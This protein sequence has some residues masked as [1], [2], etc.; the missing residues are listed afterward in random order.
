MKHVVVVLSLP[1]DYLGAALCVR[2]TL[3]DVPHHGGVAFLHRP[4]EGGLSILGGDG[5]P[6]NVK[7]NDGTVQQGLIEKIWLPIGLSC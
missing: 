3:Q 4:V 7:N 1:G 5:R 6:F 2:V